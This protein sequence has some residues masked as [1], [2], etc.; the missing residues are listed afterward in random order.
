VSVCEVG[1]FGLIDNDAT[2]G[3][4][5]S[6]SKIAEEDEWMEAG[7]EGRE[8]C[9]AQWMGLPSGAMLPDGRGTGW[10]SDPEA[11][12]EVWGW[13]GGR[14]GDEPREWCPPVAGD[15][16]RWGVR[17]ERPRT[18]VGDGSLG[19]ADGGGGGRS[20]GPACELLMLVELGTVLTELR[21][22]RDDGHGGRWSWTMNVRRQ[23]I[24]M[25]ASIKIVTR[26][27][28][29]RVEMDGCDLVSE[30]TG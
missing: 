6:R 21:A 12:D 20:A 8:R 9:A 28:R 19:S 14:E 7:E 27:S 11:S 15:R 16:A 25:G 29:E 23:M 10:M 13:M 17:A 24:R 26:V 18:V 5:I 30:V 3:S 22:C 1:W 2:A 4:S